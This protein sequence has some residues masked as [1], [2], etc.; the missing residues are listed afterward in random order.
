M[1]VRIKDKYW[2]IEGDCVTSMKKIPDEKCDALITDPPAGI[3]FM[4]KKW[5]DDKGGR[6]DW[7]K[8]LSDIMSEAMRCLKPGAHGL[9]WAIP[10]T[11]HWTTMALENA[12]FEI[13]DIITHLFGTGFPKSQNIS[14]QID[15]QAGA[16]THRSKAFNTVGRGERKDL[17]TAIK[18][19]V[20]E[21]T[22]ITDEAKQYDGWGTA[23]K[24]ASEHWILI[25]KPLSE[26]TVAKN[27]LK[28]GTGG[29]NIDACRI[30][31]DKNDPNQRPNGSIP[32]GQSNSDSSFKNIS[33]R[34]PA[35]NGNTLDM[36]K[37]RFP[38]NLVLSHNDDC[39][40]VGTKE[41]KGE[42]NFRTGGQEIFGSKIKTNA[43]INYSN[44]NGKETVS[45][46]KCSE[47]CAV[48]M[49]DEQSGTLKSGAI[50]AHHKKGLKF[51][52]DVYNKSTTISNG[53]TES[54]EGGASRF[55]YCAKAS[56]A[57]KNTGLDDFEAKKVND[58]RPSEIDNAF[59]RGET[60]RKNTHPTV[61]ST[62]LMEYLIK[63]ITPENGVVLDP[64]MGSGSTGVSARNLNKKFIG[65][66][67][68]SEYFTI[69][70][71]R[72]EYTNSDPEQ[73]EPMQKVG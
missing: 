56:G 14:I 61:K 59:Q 51:K 65:I 58:G 34:N 30:S 26:K 12:G 62:K 20:E 33:G 71:S 35:L 42:S 45:D 52:G 16:M 27:V 41:V 47:G 60:K 3:S 49:L 25:R 7:I 43:P 37:G 72:L 69:A 4:G 6:D 39:E 40:Y 21:H 22:S 38:A 29:I 23:L 53:V 55:F 64:F 24:P 10:R 8:W 57:D 73:W 1:D 68:E 11:S 46:Y 66:E 48:K 18:E 44:E 54:S 19:K 2:L 28:F 31:I 15:K 67:K 63:L 17:Q 13:R 32:C 70:K 36:A 9:V 5:D 50:L